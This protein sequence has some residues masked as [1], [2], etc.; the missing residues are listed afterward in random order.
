MPAWIR[1]SR[2]T[3]LAITLAF[4]GGLMSAWHHQATAR[5]GFCSDHGEPIHLDH[6][7]GQS[8][9]LAGP[10]SVESRE[11]VVGA[12]DCVVL[13][14]L[15]Q[16]VLDRSGQATTLA[17]VPASPLFPAL[18]GI[19]PAQISTLQLSPSNSPPRA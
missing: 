3:V 8:G 19:A 12:H 18:E 5:H 1:H 4:S 6:E 16:S 17:P 13:A 14:F 7:A 2:L 15:G 9:R 10:L 11:H